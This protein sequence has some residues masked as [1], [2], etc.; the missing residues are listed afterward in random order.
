MKLSFV[1]PYKSITFLPETELP[2]FVVLTGVNGAG[3]T[4]LLEA[5]EKGYILVD[6]ITIDE[7]IKPVR[8]FN[9]MNLV[10]QDSGA[11]AP[12]QLSQELSNFWSQLSQSIKESLPIIYNTL[13]S[14]FNKPEFLSINIRNLLNM[15]EANFIE[16]GINSNQ[17]Q[18]IPR[19]IQS[20]I[21]NAK[22]NFIQKNP[23]RQI[24]NT[25]SEL[26][27]YLEESSG[28][29]II[30]FEE[31]DFYDNFPKMGWMSVD[32]FQQ[33]FGRL[34]AEYQKNWL[35]NEIKA[36]ARYKGENVT[37]LSDEEFKEKYGEPP[38]DFLNSILEAA[39]LDFRVNQPAKYDDRPYE[40]VLTDKLRENTVL[41]ADLSSGEKILMSFALCLYYAEDSRQIVNYPKILLFDEID[42]P[43]HPSMTQ[44]LLKTI[45]N[46]LVN[47][48]TIKVILTTHSPSTVA[49]AP[50]DS[51]Y[52]MNKTGENR[53]QKTTK[54][55]ALAI[56]TSGVP[57]LS[58]D[59]EN[60]RQ[61][62]V[63]S[64]YDA[65]CYEK[66]FNK[67]NK[68]E[69]TL[70][71]EIS[72]NFIS[73]GLTSKDPN[74]GN[75]TRVK[76]IVKELYQTG[77]NKNIY[78][79]IDWD[80]NNNENEN[81]HV[82]VLGHKKRYSIENYILDP[83][84]LV[85]FLLRE[86][87]NEKIVQEI[88]QCCEI[89]LN[90]NETFMD[91]AKFNDIRLQKVADFIVNKVREKLSPSIDENNQQCEYINGQSINLPEWFLKIQGH[92]YEDILKDIFNPLKQ[93]K[94]DALKKEILNKVVDDIPQL[95]SKDFIDLFHK[96][97]NFNIY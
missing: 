72:L 96:I 22:H 45:Q 59:Y 70:I 43:L 77:G 94:N 64:D 82:K 1:K 53:L 84:L 7:Q 24:P 92:K 42:A 25:H 89:G 13:Y 86:R 78:G 68:S 55:N 66:I 19:I 67:L 85:A 26:I 57:T 15:S 20:A 90:N 58:I 44:S 75:C 2:D 8:F 88:K 12:F 48:H 23:N 63:E 81:D 14:N 49:L 83:L 91:I 95:L 18:E 69:N 56:L 28:I 35:S 93:Y 52:V 30:A 79:I 10:T 73:S 87:H 62:F 61:V 97:Q 76:D 54:D 36:C 46:V 47:R 71:S 9:W 4:H 17:A 3:K 60:R 51:I 32:I 29:P 80:I 65:K 21:Q 6:N 27:K 37:S 40:P 50:E 11:I 5:I 38:W 16:I 31:K 39:N 41:F 33:S 74:G 34:F